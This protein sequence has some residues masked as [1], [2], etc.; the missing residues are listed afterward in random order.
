MEPTITIT[1]GEEK[2]V[3]TQARRK[4]AI[5][6]A[7]R[8]KAKAAANAV[9][10]AKTPVGE[11]TRQNQRRAALKAVT[12]PRERMIR[13][14]QAA[15]QLDHHRGRRA[16]REESLAAMGFREKQLVRELVRLTAKGRP[17]RQAHR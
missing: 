4:G 12:K 17:P 6:A 5:A 16:V 3:E 1:I 2:K 10:Y 13:A 9:F 14:A 8:L 15:T 11:P 7:A